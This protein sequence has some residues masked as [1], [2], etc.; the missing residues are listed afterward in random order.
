MNSQ[1]VASYN[2]EITGVATQVRGRQQQVWGI[3]YDTYDRMT[4]ARFCERQTASSQA[5]LRN[6]YSENLTYDKRGNI[7][8]LKRNGLYLVAQNAYHSGEIDDLNYLY[9]HQ[10]HPNEKSNRLGRVHDYSNNAQ[11]YNDRN[12]TGAYSYD[13]NGNTE[14]DHSPK[15][16]VIYNHLDLAMR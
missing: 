12:H 10:A 11:G 8:T 4:E 1:P 13:D 14:I 3:E 2:R 5:T 7:K 15:V 16:Q 9:T 6:Y